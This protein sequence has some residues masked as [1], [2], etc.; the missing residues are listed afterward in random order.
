MGYCKL[1]SLA[2]SA[3]KRETE[4]TVRV[5]GALSA[6]GVAFVVVGSG[7]RRRVR[8]IGYRPDDRYEVGPE[9]RGCFDAKVETL[10]SPKRRGSEAGP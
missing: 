3:S 2:N 5:V 1:K 4:G 7:C 10:P 6:L 8:E 9:R